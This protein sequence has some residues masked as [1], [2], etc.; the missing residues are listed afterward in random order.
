[1]LTNSKLV[2][3]RWKEHLEQLYNPKSTVDRT[4]LDELET[5][6]QHH[7]EVTAPLLRSEVENAIK[8]MKM[9]K[10]PG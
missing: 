10:A 7:V 3:D 6:D 4:I 1:M 2:K 5:T 8:R 9:G